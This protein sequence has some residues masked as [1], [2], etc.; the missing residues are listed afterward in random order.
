MSDRHHK[1]VVTDY[2]YPN[3]AVESR[4]LAEAG[5]EVIGAQCKSEDELIEVARGADGLLV[6]YAR[7]GERTIA[8]L[9]KC[10]VI[11]R[12]GIGVDIVDVEAATR[13]GILVTN[14]PRYCVDEVAD[15]AVAM[16]LTLAR[17]L[18]EYDAA[19][20]QGRWHWSASGA[21]IHRLRGR[22]AG[23]VGYGKIGSS[24][25]ARLRPFGMQIAV[26]DPYADAGRVER[27]GG[28]KVDFDELLRV[29]DAL[30]IQAPLTDETRHMFDAAA[31][32]KM[33]DSTIVVNTARGPI[34]DNAALYEALASGRLAGAALDDLEEEP[35]KKRAWKPENPLLSLPNVLVSPHSAYY[36]EE[37]IEEA[38]TT[39]ASEVGRVVSGER[40]LYLVNPEVLSA[41]NLRWRP[42]ADQGRTA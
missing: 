9:D 16:F 34:M 35:A 38:R 24:I 26:Y 40:P 27:D 25:A 30:L 4:V 32:A 14:V 19:V 17:R 11:A 37:S 13:R 42:V 18:R 21:P 29:S 31:F 33:K 8:A 10:L 28:T 22:V 1:V 6:Q 36:S 41:P 20:R 5:A 3:L 39:A 23:I 15:H 12:Y 2:D 7:V